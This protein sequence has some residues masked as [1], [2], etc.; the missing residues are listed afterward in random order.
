M[1]SNMIIGLRPLQPAIIIQYFFSLC[2]STIVF[3]LR[4]KI[5]G[6]RFVR[7]ARRGIANKTSPQ[8]K[9]ANLR[10]RKERI[11]TVNKLE[12]ALPHPVLFRCWHRNQ[13]SILSIYNYFAKRQQEAFSKRRKKSFF[14]RATL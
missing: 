8:T 13:L 3:L 1:I 11:N 12:F 5:L 14:K 6:K 10:E 7:F 9:L 4:E 2:V